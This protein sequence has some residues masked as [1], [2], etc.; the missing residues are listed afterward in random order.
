MSIYCL[1]KLKNE[2]KLKI[3]DK[4]RATSLGPKFTDFCQKMNSWMNALMFHTIYMKDCFSLTKLLYTMLMLQ[5]SGR[6]DR[7][8]AAE[9]VDSVRITVG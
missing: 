7:G 4:L 9:T 6:V 1:I 3:C 5:I 2:K 8:S